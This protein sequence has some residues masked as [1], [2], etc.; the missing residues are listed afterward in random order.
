MISKNSLP[1]WMAFAHLPKVRTSK[2]NQIILDL[3]NNGITLIDFFSIENNE[4]KEVFGLDDNEL[5]ELEKGKLELANYSFLLEDLLDQGYSLIPII[6]EDYSS[7]LKNNLGL[8]SPILLYAK[9]NIDILKNPSIAIIGS[10]EANQNSIDFTD[11]IA[12][13][14]VKEKKITVS[15]YA[16]GVDQQALVSTLK[17]GGK[18]IIVLPQGITTFSTGYKTYYKE[19]IQGSVLVVSIFFPKAPWQKEFAMAR[20]PIIYA[21][22]DN[23]YVAESSEKGGTWSGVID[24]LR[25]KR[26][27]FIRIPE[28]D[29]KNANNILIDKGGIGVDN[30]GNKVLDYNN[31]ISI[32]KEKTHKD[33]NLII[34]E[35]IIEII[36]NKS[37]NLQQIIIKLDIQITQEKLRS[38][39][40]NNKEIEIIKEKGKNIYRL[41]SISKNTQQ[42]LF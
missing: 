2:K 26:A 17:Y 9:G 35:K 19:I 42:S 8:N 32:T 18:S 6:S 3:I 31:P 41:K 40:K 4:L 20:N 38:I 11:K 34:G 24:G 10:R 15:G 36:G 27:V 5:I 29:E 16:K 12:N 1:Y 23:I 28:I 37:L 14:A 7:T 13:K 33:S 25:K 21:L 30:Y 22:A 39:L